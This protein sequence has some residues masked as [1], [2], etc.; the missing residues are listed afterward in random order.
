VQAGDLPYTIRDLSMGSTSM[1]QVPTQNRFI[2]QLVK[3][4]GYFF[5]RGDGTYS[6]HF[7]N[8]EESANFPFKGFIL[9]GPP[10]SGKTEAVIEAGR[11]LFKTMATEGIETRLFHVNSA[12]INRK[13]LGDNEAR[14]RQVFR[15]AKGLQQKGLRTIVLFDDIETLLV[16]RTDA[17]TSEWSRT[18]NGVFFHEVDQ[19]IT[20]RTMIV[21]TTNE[22]DLIDDAVTS[23]LSLHE[24][25]SPNL[26]EMIEVSKTCIP[27]AGANGLTRDELHEKCGELIKKSLAEGELPSFRLAR[28][29]AIEILMSDVVGWD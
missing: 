7:P 22:P 11:T 12:N 1:V 3:A 8:S 17:H 6:D 26:E 2:S 16:K 24:A 5:G 20:T 4:M 9:A 15:D 19:L 28:K 27:I 29:S 10:G 23:R 14:L 18:I 13:G 25:P 21:A